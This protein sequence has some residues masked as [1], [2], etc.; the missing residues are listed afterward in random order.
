MTVT[1]VD[2]GHVARSTFNSTGIP[3]RAA[4]LHPRNKHRLAVLTSPIANLN[5]SD[6]IYRTGLWLRSLPFTGSIV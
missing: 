1:M 4:G 2:D 6:L 3:D 5:H